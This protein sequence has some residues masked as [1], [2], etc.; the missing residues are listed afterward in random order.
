MPQSCKPKKV[1]GSN[2][3]ECRWNSCQ[4][5]VPPSPNCARWQLFHLGLLVY[6]GLSFCSHESS[7]HRVFTWLLLIV[8]F[9]F[10]LGLCLLVFFLPCTF[11]GWAPILDFYLQSF[12]IFANE[13]DLE[14]PNGLSGRVCHLSI[15]KLLNPTGFIQKEQKGAPPCI[16]QHDLL[17]S[18]ALLS[19][20]HKRTNFCFGKSCTNI[21]YLIYKLSTWVSYTMQI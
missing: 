10:F 3:V 2:P 17:I 16:V 11:D 6:C 1:L 8:C 12:S 14:V 4:P 5:Y 20:K 7:L 21:W 19:Q 18:T 15:R 13:L 9:W